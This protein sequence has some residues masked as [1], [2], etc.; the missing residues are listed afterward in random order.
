V[1]IGLDHVSVT[2]ADLA[3]SLA[4]Y[5]DLL[6]LP[7]VARGESDEEELAVLTGLPAVRI[8]WAELTLSGDCVLELLQYVRPV[9]SPLVQLPCD[10]GTTHIGLSVEDI[11]ALQG[12][13]VDAGVEIVSGPV[14]L[15]EDGWR[16]V[17]CLYA[18]DPDGVTIELVERAPVRDAVAVPDLEAASREGT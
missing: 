4:F 7:L 12:R 8:E 17:R 15:R 14:A 5:R 3:A 10:P 9:A 16:A 2:T 18:K 1:T 6:G 13:L 11:D